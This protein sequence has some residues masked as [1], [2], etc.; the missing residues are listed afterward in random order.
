MTTR[1]TVLLVA[2]TVALSAADQTTSAP[3][4]G[5][6]ASTAKPGT[7]VLTVV[8]EAGAAID[9]AK[10]VMHG[11]VD[12]GGTS[13]TDG[14]VTFQNVPAG[15]YRGR[16]TRDG[17]VTLDKE[18]VVRAGTSSKGEAVLAAAPPAPAPPPP[19]PP[20]PVEAKPA[21]LAAG[22]PATGDMAAMIETIAR[23]KEPIVERELGCSGATTSK[24]IVAKENI[25]A[26]RH[27]DIDEVLYVIAGEA[28]LTL[29]D[30][31][32]VISPGWFGLV[33]RGMSHTLTRRGRNILALLSVQSG[34]PCK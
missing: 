9:D 6:Q 5:A 34:Q 32:Q 24:V 3:K 2:A 12:R 21:P 17:Y 11:P 13:G 27:T 20:A 30:K 28:T 7:F 31:D 22:N 33:P 8:T 10:V 1:M 23:G 19:P 14:L 26:H 16:I 25:P 29:G 15:T 4:P 18:V